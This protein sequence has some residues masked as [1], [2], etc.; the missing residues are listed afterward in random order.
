[1]QETGAEIFLDTRCANIAQY[2]KWIIFG[3]IF[4]LLLFRYTYK[5]VLMDNAVVLTSIEIAKKWELSP[6]RVSVLCA[7]GRITGAIKKGK[8]WLIPAF[9]ERP[10]DL[11]R[12]EESP[13]VIEEKTLDIQNRRFL[14]NKYKLLDFIDE[15]I[16]KYCP[17]TN[18]ILDIFAGTGVV[19]KHFSDKMDVITN[20]IL[21][22]N[23]ISHIAFMSHEHADTLKL[24]TIAN[25][26]NNTSTE[27]I[28]ENYMSQTF[29]DT[30]FSYDDCKKIGYIR[31]KIEK[32]KKDNIVND[33]ERAILITSLL[34]SMD[35]IANTCG[36][37]DAFI[38]GAHFDKR[39]EYKLI[40]ITNEFVNSAKFY[41]GDANK[42]I[43]D[44]D[45]SY[46]DCV[47]CD[48]PYN[49]RNYSDLYHV[50]ENVA[51]WEKPEVEGVARKM[52]RTAIKSEYCSKDAAKAFED[53]VLNLNCKYIVLSYNNTGDKADGRSNARI[54]DDEIIRILKMRGKVDVYSKKYKAF[55]TGKSNNTTNEER[56]FVCTVKE[57]LVITAK[58]TYT[59]SPLNY[60][61]GK[62]K[63]MPQIERLFPDNINTFVDL[64][65]GGGNVGVN[66]IA[67]R[68]IYNDLDRN[69]IRLLNF[70][71]NNSFESIDKQISQIIVNYSLSN[72]E[73]YGYKYYG[74]NSSDGLG[75]YNKKAFQKL[76]Q[77]FN[78]SDRNDMAKLFT[79]I[80]FGF[81]NQ[82]RFNNKG[83]YNL[84]VGKRDYNSNTRLN[85]ANFCRDLNLQDPTIL[86]TDFRN[87][88]ISTLNG[89]DIIYCDPPYL[90]TTATYNEKNGWS[91]TDEKDLLDFLTSVDRRGI[92]FA[93]SNVLEHKGR[94]N[95]LL[96]NWS[97]Q[98]KIHDLNFSYNNSNYHSTAS[99]HKT[100]E[101]L[102][103][104]Y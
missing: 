61:G 7:E 91:E 82:I 98:Y 76:R 46:V 58:K 44:A 9:S 12:K 15:I 100:R 93:L 69:V 29:G 74:C 24:K 73:A 11:R 79:L 87:F 80:I 57:P 95:D 90:I 41:N 26:L 14:G 68:T 40:K 8:T 103:T 22:S 18:S 13:I 35:K 50:L 101:V 21:Y 17:G 47:Y 97:K 51:K 65:C 34:Y 38:K 60:T 102:I 56:L 84:P 28:P 104:N 43:K 23:Y 31:D 89:D 6:R 94:K 20:D 42:I 45:F 72:S 78:N 77:D 86:N 3:N 55:T 48:P 99:G 19:A 32:Y 53:L 83:E 92:K 1:M 5:I 39:F 10:I 64:F 81:N 66:V 85:L 67:K 70:F 59:K 49:S 30:Y 36:H 71:K 88:D 4:C 75:K 37:Y 63:L 27:T 2:D 62:T 25:E 16:T 52:D 96:D 33:R 54:S